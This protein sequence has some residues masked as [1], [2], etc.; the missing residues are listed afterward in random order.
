MKKKKDEGEVYHRKKKVVEQPQGEVWR[1]PKA[2][3]PPPDLSKLMTGDFLPESVW[4]HCV[5]C[6]DEREEHMHGHLLVFG[7][8]LL[9]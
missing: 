5:Q 8:R 4:V 1:R 6:L 3:P 7:G 9:F 2:P